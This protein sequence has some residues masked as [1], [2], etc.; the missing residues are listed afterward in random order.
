MGD[1]KKENLEAASAEKKA[2]KNKKKKKSFFKGVKQEW[3]KITWPTAGDVTKQTFIVVAV[4]FIMAA[5][6]AAI[7]LGVMG[8]RYYVAPA[9]IDYLSS[10]L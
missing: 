1:V 4:T 5:I 7:D 8:V 9:V 3:K 2:P 10:K 6:I